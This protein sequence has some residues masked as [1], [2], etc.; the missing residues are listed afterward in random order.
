MSD[1][2]ILKTDLLVIGGGPGGYTAAFRAADLGMEVILIDENHQLGG[3]WLNKGC[4]PSKSLL[5]LSSIIDESKEASAMG[6]K[7]KSPEISVKSIHEWKNNVINTLNEG[8]SKLSKARNIKVLTGHASFKSA[9]L[10]SVNDKQD[11]NIDVN[12]NNC[13]ISTGSNPSII[14]HLNKNHPS[15]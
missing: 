5:H 1:V 4:I 9:N 12:F 14:Q 3:V 2:S 6:V 13:I 11:K 8:I 10:V 7:F 15:I